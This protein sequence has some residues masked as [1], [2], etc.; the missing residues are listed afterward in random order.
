MP[1]SPAHLTARPATSI[2]ASFAI[3]V[4]AIMRDTVCSNARL[5]TS[6]ILESAS[7]VQEMENAWLALPQDAPHVLLVLKK[8]QEFVSP[9]VK[10]AQLQALYTLAPS[11]VPLLAQVALAQLRHIAC[12]VCQDLCCSVLNA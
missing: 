3:L 10:P 7:L 4:S 12:L 8:Y 9:F 11:P 6:A 1:A 5:C 2:F